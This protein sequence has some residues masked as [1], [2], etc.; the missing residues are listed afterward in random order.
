[1]RTSDRASAPTADPLADLLRRLATSAASP[2][3]RAWA[4]RL[5]EGER[6]EGSTTA[7]GP[8]SPPARGASIG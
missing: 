3:V 7:R 8:E 6:A 5:S 1:M 2:A 4:A